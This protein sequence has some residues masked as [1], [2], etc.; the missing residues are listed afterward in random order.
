MAIDGFI[1]QVWAATG[2]RY[3]DKAHV[4][5][6]PGVV[7]RDY[8]GDIN[9]MGDTVK[10]NQIGPVTISAYVKNTDLGTPQT[11]TGAQTSLV[12]DQ[13]SSFNFQIDRIDQVQQMPKV[14]GIAMQRAA[15]GIAETIDL[16]VAADMAANVDAT[17]IETAT[18]LATA[19]NAFVHIANLSKLMSEAN[20]PD[21]GRVLIVPNWYY[22]ILAQDTARFFSG[23][24]EKGQQNLMNGFVG[25]VMGF[26]VLK[27]NSTYI[28]SGTRFAAA[29]VDTCY[30]INPMAYSFVE[31]IVDVVNY[32]PE[33][34]FAEA[35]KGLD[36]YGYKAV[37]PSAFGI[38]KATHP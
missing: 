38:I 18:D 25:E 7:N 37:L 11:L 29:S 30:G 4:F 31:Q 13:A 36:V 9:G 2:L 28:W 27:S 32:Q 3:L 35:V 22:T 17:N 26:R 8:E 20:I 24:S 12:V 10:I 14:M 21:E 23:Y 15:Y 1:P 34:R 6:Q 33:K 16:A 5:V 19:A